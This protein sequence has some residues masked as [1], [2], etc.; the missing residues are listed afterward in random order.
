MSDDAKRNRELMPQ[1]AVIRDEFKRV[2]GPLTRLTWASENGR[3]VGHRRAAERSMDAD[4]WI[5][6]LKT[7]VLPGGA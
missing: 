2:F 1:T 5:H 3:E 4:A 7:G 6:Y